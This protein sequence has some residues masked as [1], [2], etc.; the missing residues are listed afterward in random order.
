MPI[1]NNMLPRLAKKQPMLKK[2]SCELDLPSTHVH[3]YSQMS[4]ALIETYDVKDNLWTEMDELETGI[5]LNEG[6]QEV[7]SQSSGLLHEQQ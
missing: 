4:T 5:G 2:S 6:E 3:P 1:V 7:G